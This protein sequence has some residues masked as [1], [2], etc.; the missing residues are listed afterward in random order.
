VAFL[1]ACWQWFI[2]PHFDRRVLVFIGL[3]GLF[4]T[5]LLIANLVGSLLFSFPLPFNTPIGQQVLL[6]A[7]IIFFPLTFL[8][9]DLINEFYGTRAA[10]FITVLGLLMAMV[11]YGFFKVAQHLPVDPRTVLPQAEFLHF[12]TLYT[13]MLVA[14]LTAY[15][16][17]QLL[18]IQLFD[19]FHAL[20][21]HKYLWLRAQGSTLISQLFD[22]TIVVFIAFW[23]QLPVADL[24]QLSL[25]NYIWKFLIVVAITPALYA[26]H[27][28]LHRLVSAPSPH[29]PSD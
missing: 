26:G 5:S 12:S 23:G 16:V 6:S 29:P 25:S 14:S 21:K 13:H 11:V 27:A 9:T 8:L 15:L 19:W 3:T 4:L 2:P 7:G 1:T 28:A 10:R 18:D 17:G 20:T 24:W 22:S